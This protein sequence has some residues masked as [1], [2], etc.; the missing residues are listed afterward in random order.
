MP[1][2]VSRN[3][4]DRFAGWL[5]NN[6]V[7]IL[8]LSV[9][10]AALGGYLASRMTIKPDLVNLLPSSQRSVKDLVAITKRAKPFGTVQVVIESEDLA[11]RAK[12][13]AALTARLATLEK[14]RPDLVTVFSPDDGPM[15]RYAW[16]HRFLFASLEDLTAAR[17]GLKARIDRE[18][19]GVNPAYI[20]LDD[21]PDESEAKLEEVEQ[22]LAD[23]EAKAAAP[24]PRVSPD[25]TLQLL[26][27]Q[28]AFPPSDANRAKELIDL[29][30][31]AIDDTRA[32]T[33][34]VRFG[35]AGNVTFAMHEHDSV[36]E[37]MALSGLI[38][39]VL[40]AF[41]LL[42][43]YRSGKIVLAM[44]WS[45]AVGVLA[46][47]ASAWLVIGHLNVMTA[48]LTAIVVGNGINAGLL[49][50]A[51][52]LEEVRGGV[53]P[54]AALAPAIAG[55]LR[56]TLAATATAAVSYASLLI[57]D[58]RGFRQFGGIAGAGMLLTWIT[59][60]TVLPALLLAL[61]RRGMIKPSKPPSVGIILAKLMPH[62]HRG[63]VITM[64]FG[65]LL[66]AAA[67]AVT[68]VYIAQD[69]FTHDWR[70]LQSSTPAIRA[71]QRLD[72]KVKK[73]FDP[74]SLLSGQAF[75]VVIG[76]DRRDQVGP[77]V[78]MLQAT[79]AD[80]P[81][82]KEW[83]HDVRSMDDLLP[84]DQAA[85]QPILDAIRAMIDDPTLRDALDD[86]EKAKLDKLRPPDKIVA[87]TDA[88]APRELAWPFVENDGSIG[89]L[90]VVRGSK[91]FKSFNVDHRLEFAAEVRKLRLPPGA[92]IAGESLVV[93][94]IIETMEEDA[95]NMVAFALAG[96]VLAVFFVVG[97]RRHGLITLA[98]GLAGV[99][100][101]IAAC[102][103]VG[104][105]VHFLDLIALPITIG[106]GI[107]YAV[108]LAARD[109]QDGQRG[110]H[111]LLRTTGGAVLL[112]SYTTT[113]GY[114]TLMLSANGGIRAFGEAALIGEVA[115][116]TMALI[117]APAW[118]TL[119]R[120]KDVK[121]EN[122]AAL[123]AP[124]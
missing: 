40:C 23:L 43:F 28:T 59:T 107:D 112:A 62:S 91:R 95:P 17:D 26:A 49:L 87:L 39:V 13:G 110:P 55:A 2:P 31:R 69:P 57:T 108:N 53:E 3:P 36:L 22:K 4:A 101:M 9:L 51:R 6:R 46:T 76:V 70:D 124:A 5:D 8:V 80:R 82:E 27:I 14:A 117:V 86:E 44:L 71:A 94:D 38:T 47:F 114:G 116:I 102:A 24:P 113:V 52:Y 93:A 30:R 104:L 121:R 37:G 109:R 105:K 61:A 75:Q 97:L 7:G 60:F 32:Q 18:K 120:Q 25:G 106:I 74:K 63:L 67:V 33:P 96:S 79:D 15:H 54:R 34:S 10:L 19:L 103:V 41:A 66:T 98:C 123:N 83:I 89:R 88:D 118:L 85:K 29:V 115:C 84:A 64:I 56:G 77:V 16:Q 68:T 100:V 92:V 122:P 21:E 35:L 42:L 48:F 50:V 81:P 11:L 99:V 20:D 119:L 78:A 73:A 65:G 12:A 72:D 58:F 90:I 1:I 45:L 111:H